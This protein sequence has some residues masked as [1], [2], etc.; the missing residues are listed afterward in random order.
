MAVA[1][2]AP[3][4]LE[5]PVQWYLLVAHH[6]TRHP[7]LAPEPNYRPRRPTTVALPENPVT[8]TGALR[9]SDSRRAAYHAGKHDTQMIA[10]AG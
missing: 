10:I 6:H 7:D 1:C 3:L 9:S 5:L 4:S 8:H 2:S